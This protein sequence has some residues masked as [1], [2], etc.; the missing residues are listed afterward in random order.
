ML[1]RAV[2]VSYRPGV[3]EFR[4]AVVMVVVLHAVVVLADDEL[5][6][7]KVGG[8]APLPIINIIITFLWAAPLLRRCPELDGLDELA[9][10]DEDSC[11]GFW[12]NL[13]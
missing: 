11:E 5:S 8:R 10:Y 6:G 2:I 13:S 1:S 3:C 9:S 12:S 4:Q 7:D